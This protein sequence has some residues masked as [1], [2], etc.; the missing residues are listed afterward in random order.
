[1]SSDLGKGQN[2][3]L[4]RLYFAVLLDA[5][6]MSSCVVSAGE[7]RLRERERERERETSVWVAL[8]VKCDISPMSVSYTHLT[9]PTNIAV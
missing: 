3:I 4:Y 2:I 8:K 7:P 5:A 6:T 1:M 9:L